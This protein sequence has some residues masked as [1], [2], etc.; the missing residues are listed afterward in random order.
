M[1]SL[2]WTQRM[3]TRASSTERDS[4]SFQENDRNER[5]VCTGRIKSVTSIQR[6]S[7]QDEAL[8]RLSS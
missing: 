6:T 4:L 8:T 1:Q 2:L 3:W 7:A 5:T